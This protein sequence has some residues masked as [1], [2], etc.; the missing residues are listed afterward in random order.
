MRLVVLSSLSVIIFEGC[1]KG[2]NNKINKHL[3]K[4]T[5]E[6]L[7]VSGSF[8]NNSEI[9]KTNQDYSYFGLLDDNTNNDLN[10]NFNQLKNLL[11]SI[12]QNIE[13]SENF[14]ENDP[15]FIIYKNNFNEIKS[16]NNS[17]DQIYLINIVNKLFNSSAFID[18]LLSDI[19]CKEELDLFNLLLDLKFKINV[20][21]PLNEID[22]FESKAKLKN[23]IRVFID[24]KNGILSLFGILNKNSRKED[25]LKILTEFEQKISKSDNINT[26]RETLKE[27]ILNKNISE[28]IENDFKWG[29][30]FQEATLYKKVIN[31]YL[32]VFPE[33]VFFNQGEFIK[34][35]KEGRI[36]AEVYKSLKNG[37][38]NGFTKIFNYYEKLNKGAGTEYLK[39]FRMAVEFLAHADIMD[40]EVIKNSA[41]LLELNSK[42]HNETQYV[43]KKIDIDEI[44]RTNESNEISIDETVKI[45]SDNANKSTELL[46]F[47]SNS[48]HIFSATR[49]GEDLYTFF[50]SNGFKASNVNADI[51][52]SLI[53]NSKATLGYSE[54]YRIK[55]LS[56]GEV[57]NS[58][59]AANNFLQLLDEQRDV[60]L[61]LQESILNFKEK[62][63]NISKIPEDMLNEY[64]DMVKNENRLITTEFRTISIVNSSDNYLYEL[65]IEEKIKAKDQL[66]ILKYLKKKITNTTEI[67]QIIS[68]AEKNVKFFERKYDKINDLYTRNDII[69]SME[70]E[71]N[72]IKTQ[73]DIRM[74]IFKNKNSFFRRFMGTSQQEEKLKIKNDEIEKLRANIKRKI[75]KCNEEAIEIIYNQKP[76]NN[77]ETPESVYEIEGYIKD[78][79]E[80]TSKNLSSFAERKAYE[81]DHSE[82][83]LE[84]RDNLK[85][86]K[87][88]VLENYVA[89]EN[90][91]YGIQALSIENDFNNLIED[92]V[93]SYE[94][95]NNSIHNLNWE[96]GHDQNEEFILENKENN[97]I[98]E[99]NAT[100]TRYVRFK[101]LSEFTVNKLRWGY[102]NGSNILNFGIN[103]TFLYLILTR[104]DIKE[105]PSAK[106][107]HLATAGVLGTQS[108]LEA[109]NLI[110]SFAEHLGKKGIGFEGVSKVL[111]RAVGYA[112]IVIMAA[113]IGFDIKNLHETEAGSIDE[114]DA[115]LR[116]AADSFFSIAALFSPASGPFVIPATISIVVGGV[117]TDQVIDEMVFGKIMYERFQYDS[118]VFHNI[119]QGM[120]NPYTIDSNK[121]VRFSSNAIISS[122]NLESGEI[123]YGK[124]ITKVNENEREEKNL[125]DAFMSEA[126]KT[127]DTKYL[128]KVFIVPV[129]PDLKYSPNEQTRD[130]FVFTDHNLYESQEYQT[131]KQ[132]YG[133]IFAENGKTDA[134]H[135]VWWKWFFAVPFL[136]LERGQ[137]VV[138]GKFEKIP[139]SKTIEFAKNSARSIQFPN[140]LKTDY[141]NYLSYKLIGKG[142][143]NDISLGNTLFQGVTLNSTQHDVWSLNIDNLYEKDSKDKFAISSQT[144]K[145][146]QIHSI[147]RDINFQTLIK[148]IRFDESESSIIL[149]RILGA[150]RKIKVNGDFANIYLNMFLE[151]NDENYVKIELLYDKNKKNFI[152]KNVYCQETTINKGNIFN[153]LSVKYSALNF[154]E[155]NIVQLHNNEIISVSHK[156]RKISLINL[157]VSNGENGNIIQYSS[158]INSKSEIFYSEGNLKILP[159]SQ[160]N[161]FSIVKSE[162]E[163]EFNLTIK[164]DTNG[165]KILSLIDTLNETEF[166]NLVRRSINNLDDLARIKIE[167]KDNY[168]RKNIELP[169][170]L[171][172]IQYKIKADYNKNISAEISKN[173]FDI[174][175]ET[176]HETIR[177]KKLH[178]TSF[179][180][181]GKN[182][183]SDFISKP[184]EQYS[185]VYDEYYKLSTTQ[186]TV[187]IPYLTDTE[188]YIHSDL[189]YKNH[190]SPLI[191]ASNLKN[192]YFLNEESVGLENIGGNTMRILLSD[193]KFILN[194]YKYKDDLMIWNGLENKIRVK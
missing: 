104:D 22:I 131:I 1:D 189:Y 109:R 119:F 19:R 11:A 133:G 98:L 88:E 122:I 34:K 184:Q 52:K 185:L 9:S 51:L 120:I 97:L 144:Y 63:K 79:I 87:S 183:S 60:L 72:L 164:F 4:Q 27:Y 89:H 49:E 48:A 43:T 169:G 82:E 148:Q 36:D 77:N 25:F 175:Y 108:V 96:V 83:T 126:K 129:E 92:R 180:L 154:D 146:T 170:F 149:P 84:A 17:N 123:K 138:T 157:G 14:D 20:N 67:D 56:N 137:I 177:D 45:I 16:L 21:L 105:S 136:S 161:I 112:G 181:F 143:F 134:S 64:V 40:E 153:E 106:A 172:D 10:T 81:G 193:G 139:T 31:T 71:K 113:N 58:G 182:K 3:E 156:D 74:E 26:F 90:I 50:D 54:Q 107:I 99:L 94:A 165:I 100:D 116:L 159:S 18:R 151:R 59:S 37:N 179:I 102:Q 53:L 95:S 103:S 33:T 61:K 6:K 121:Y 47:N 86:F 132:K 23:E 69:K 7:L 124:I 62:N 68:K 13:N 192:I 186:D 190:N 167:F 24:S 188:L 41:K 115:K 125:D 76:E 28:K 35:I 85:E 65:A 101:K 114:Y 80:K 127:I 8:N 30:T 155:A 42:I 140:L 141:E 15:I 93:Q 191:I 150:E 39:N 32:S 160:E 147:N 55:Q 163:S 174:I 5:F 75:D 194:L 2:K 73:N 187:I 12:L 118:S 46:I 66:R 162:K 91:V 110:N 135:M 29:T 57:Y 178:D 130:V 158:D 117:V 128:E 168:F 152:I 173:D 176:G 44:I 142:G 166:K 145:E 111:G 38:C 171:S 70:E 78:L